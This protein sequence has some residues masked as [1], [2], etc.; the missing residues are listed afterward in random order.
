MMAE[1]SLIE[2]LKDIKMIKGWRTAIVSLLIAIFG[3]LEAFD[4][5]SILTPDIAGYVVTA[6]GVVMFILRAY[7]KTPLGKN[8]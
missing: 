3:A 4:F 1:L 8:A 5:T 2:L 6:I 7:T